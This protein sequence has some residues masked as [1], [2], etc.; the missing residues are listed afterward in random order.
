MMRDRTEDST[1]KGALQKAANFSLDHDTIAAL[2]YQLWM[3]RARPIGSPEV[4]W[5]RAEQELKNAVNA[6][7]SAA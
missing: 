4:D 5:F 6:V 1:T 7:P 3:L 2:A